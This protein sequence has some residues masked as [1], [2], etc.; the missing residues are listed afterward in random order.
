VEKFVDSNGKDMCAGCGACTEACPSGAIEMMPDEE[1]FCYPH[2]D[3]GLCDKCGLCKCICPELDNLPKLN[4]PKYVYAV[5]HRSIEVLEKSTSGGLF[6]ALAEHVISDKGTVYGAAANNDLTPNHIRINTLEDI[7]L[8]RGAKY[9]ESDLRD[10]FSNV[11]QD[12]NN[13]MEVL[14]SGT[15]CQNAGLKVVLQQ[16]NINMESLLMVD[17][18]CFGVASTELFREYINF[19]EEKNGNK[20]VRYENRSKDF[21]WGKH[22]EKA[23][24]ADGSSDNNS[25]FVKSWRDICFNGLAL[26]PSCLKCK[27]SQTARVSDITMGDF[28]GVR[29]AHRD[30]YDKRG[31]SLALVN[32]EK[33]V[34]CF[35]AINGT[36]VESVRSSIENC[37]KKNPCL[38]RSAEVS[39][40]DRAAFWRTYYD[41]GISAVFRK[42]GRFNAKGRLMNFMGQSELLKK[43]I[44]SL[45]EKVTI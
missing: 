36:S 8:C 22:V 41:G 26:R 40:D 44:L 4:G 43:I 31:I 11:A 3:Y 35:K 29:D 18:V 2:I 34:E 10:T 38:Q 27:Y 19:S 23:F 13:G 28:W 12:L 45:R 37:T 9:A 39:E 32:T 21:G 42:Y 24:Y 14:F 25:I 30:F 5:K 17:F 33:G 1:G 16:L 7:A 15:P 6:T 20:I